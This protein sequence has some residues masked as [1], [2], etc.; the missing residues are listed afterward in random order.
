M[1]GFLTEDGYGIDVSAVRARYPEVAW[2]SFADWAETER[3]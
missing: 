1:Y 2:I 3:A